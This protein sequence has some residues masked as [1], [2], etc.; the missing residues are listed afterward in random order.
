[1]RN[2]KFFVKDNISIP[3]TSIPII[4]DIEEKSFTRACAGIHLVLMIFKHAFLQNH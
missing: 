4:L 2:I 1:M 3:I